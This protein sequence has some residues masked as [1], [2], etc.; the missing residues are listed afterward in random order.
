MINGLQSLL[1]WCQQQQ[2]DDLLKKWTDGDRR[3]C[4]PS[5]SKLSSVPPSSKWR[6]NV[7]VWIKHRFVNKF[8]LSQRTWDTS[9]AVKTSHGK[10]LRNRFPK[11]R[12]PVCLWLLSGGEGWNSSDEVALTNFIKTN[13]KPTTTFK[14][15]IKDDLFYLQD[16]FWAQEKKDNPEDEN[17][18]RR[19]QSAKM[20]G[21]WR[22]PWWIKAIVKW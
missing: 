18:N 3:Q 22:Q 7:K 4:D 17:S 9:C 15:Y 20:S 6:R 1:W 13:I 19:T 21:I 2:T 11:R 5:S 12:F 14:L 8:I 16:E 10:H